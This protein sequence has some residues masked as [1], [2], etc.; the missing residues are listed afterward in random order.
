MNK[1]MGYCG[2]D[3]GKCIPYIARKENNDELRRK[4]AEEQSQ[5]F[6]MTIEPETI[7]CDGC[8]SDGEHLGFCNMCEIRRC[9]KEKEI[10]NCAYCED[11]IC[12]ELAKVYNVMCEVFKKSTNNVADAKITLDAIRATLNKSE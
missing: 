2:V 11:Y 3:C 8:I 12:D 6:E 9:C 4:Y 1:M 10:E 5:F 7:N